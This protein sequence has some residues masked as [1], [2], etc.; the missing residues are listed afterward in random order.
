MNT[1][2]CTKTGMAD[3]GVAAVMRVVMLPGLELTFKCRVSIKA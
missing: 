2:C 3:V 1:S